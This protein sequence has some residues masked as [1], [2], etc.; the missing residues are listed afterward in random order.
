MVNTNEVKL[1]LSLISS[2]LRKWIYNLITKNI[3]MC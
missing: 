2:E 1:I 3:I